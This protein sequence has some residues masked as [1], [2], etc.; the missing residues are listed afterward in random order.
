MLARGLANYIADQGIATEDQDLFFRLMPDSPDNAIC[1][2]GEAGLITSEMHSYQADSFGSKW[3]IR[4]SYAWAQEKTDQIHKAIA[5]LTGTIDGIYIL[6][7]F[8]QTSP[9][10]AENDDKG[11]AVFSIH[12]IHDCE[13]S[14]SMHRT[15]I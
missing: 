9:A 11:R 12:Y 6:A 14:G 15:P 4:G 1:V 10:F 2:Y 8:I 7:T 3:L 13:V 5:G